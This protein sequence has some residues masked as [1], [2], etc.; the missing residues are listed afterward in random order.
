MG[1]GNDPDGSIA[2]FAWQQVAG[3]SV[4]LDTPGARATRFTSPEVG[5]DIQNLSF[6]FTVT[7]S[8]GATASDE[9]VVT[10]EKLFP[11]K[12]Q[13]TFDLVPMVAQPR[14]MLDYGAIEVRP[15]RG[16]RVQLVREDQII[17]SAST[18]DKGLF[19]VLA[20]KT[21]EVRVRVRAELLQDEQNW[22]A[23]VLDNTRDYALYT[24]EGG[25]FMATDASPSQ[26]LH[27]ASGW[28]GDGIR[29]GAGSGTLCNTRRAH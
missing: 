6:R 10:V 17:D 15:V 4:A 21:A 1:S 28:T 13:V 25:P 9:V 2:S 29:R 26:I 3:P 5:D 7:D 18:D 12:G 11:I 19:S 27:A 20:S 8:H 22:Y 23:R 14:A 24:M 16:A